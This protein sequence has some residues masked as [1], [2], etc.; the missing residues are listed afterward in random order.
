M[1]EAQEEFQNA[2]ADILRVVMFEN[3]LRFYFI[4]EEENGQDKEKDLR[5]DLPDKSLKKISELYPDLL[6]LAEK[7][8]NRHIDFSTSRN[9]VLTFVLDWLDG[10]KL[11]RGLAQTVFSSSTFQ[12]RLQLFYAW[13]QMHEDQLDMGFVD[14]STWLDLFYKWKSSPGARELEEKLLQAPH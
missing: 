7:L 14:F 11:P 6:P 1:P 10:K 12:A 5:I 4:S 9:A 8:N 3:W 2:V 13:L